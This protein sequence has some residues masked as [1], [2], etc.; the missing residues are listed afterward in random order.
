M[1]QTA[2]EMNHSETAFVVPKDGGTFQEGSVFGLRWF[3][4]T[5][6]VDLCGHAT[7]ATAAVLFFVERT[8][9]RVGVLL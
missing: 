6:E 7:M 4:P 3:T 5:R 8:C 2:A 9:G 1:Q